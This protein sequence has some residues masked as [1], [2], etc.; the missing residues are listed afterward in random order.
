IVVAVAVVYGLTFLPAL[1]AV[2]GPNVD[3]LRLP[4]LGRRR[5]AGTGA[6]HSMALWVMKR[7]WVVLV[8]SLALLL[9]AGTP[10]LQLRL[11]NGDVDQLPPR[12]EARQGYDTLVSDFPGY[13]QTTI[14]AVVYYPDSGPLTADH[15]GAIY[16]LSQHLATLPNVISVQSI[17]SDT[18]LT[19]ADYITLY[20]G[21][22]TAMPAEL[23]QA[24]K[25]G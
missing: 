11:A 15:V 13:D 9:I 7:P 8:P 6:W 25:L 4:F 19:R 20:T 16:N 1:L 24:L 17:V 2:M 5:P 14:T 10:F 3:R 18:K 21:P 12:N 23:Q 22:T